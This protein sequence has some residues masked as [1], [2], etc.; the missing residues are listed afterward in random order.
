MD[1]QIELV[2][3]T[4]INNSLTVYEDQLIKFLSMY[5]LPVDKVLVSI[6]ERKKVIKNFD[7]ALVLLNTDYRLEAFYISK[8]MAAVSAGLFD[9]A[10]NYLWDETIKQLRIRVSHYDIQYFYD[11]SV[12]SDKRKR[13]NGI[14]DLNKLDDSELINGAKEID[15]ISDLGYR[16][17]DHIK[18]MRNWASAAH[19]NQSEITGLQLI[20]WLETCIKE[21][22][23]LPI[24]NVTIEIGKLLKNIKENE[25]NK[26]DADSIASFFCNLSLEKANSLGAGLFGIYT[27]IDTNEITRQ[28]INLLLPM[29][30]SRI[31]NTTKDELG[32]KYARFVANGDKA[33]AKLCR[34]FLALVSGEQFLPENVRVTEINTAL[35]NLREAHNSGTGNFYKE[36]SFVKQ[37]QRLVG[38]HG[39]PKII[40]SNYVHIIIDAFLTN[41]NGVC[42]DADSIYIEL[43]KNFSERQVIIAIMS[44][45]SDN[46][47]SKLQ[48]QLCLKKYDE[49]IEILEPK[50]AIPAVQE[51]LYKIKTYSGDK[52]SMREDDRIN[53][54]VYSES[55]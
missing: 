51:M 44:F 6:S 25:I 54:L 11:I 26:D 31:D 32:I 18:Y 30:W 1:N 23:S 40:D 39:I 41:G 24:S 9:A 38:T 43:I 17:L 52:C 29:L 22:I 50:I 36:P 48:F 35:E 45:L 21:V 14:E 19:P 37:L 46:I 13:L 49:L 47:S 3:N 16:H 10:L 12:Q 55:Y 33:E 7:D 42:W 27:R 5:N 28:N 15:L 4:S 20:S 34:S 53:K 8:F 2:S